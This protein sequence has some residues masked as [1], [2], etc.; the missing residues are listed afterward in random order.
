LSNNMENSFVKELL[1]MKERMEALYSQNFQDVQE[2]SQ[3]EDTLEVWRP[4]ADVWETDQFWKALI[5]LPGVISDELQVLVQGQRLV[6]KGVRNTE[7]VSEKPEASSMERPSGHFARSFVLPEEIAGDRI[8]AELKLG[9]LTVV[10][11]KNC[12]Q[13]RKVT[14][15]SE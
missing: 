15:R 5:D 3:P 7:M 14:V 2:V 10:I 12:K 6:V 8:K 1:G 11:P 13:S 4:M 9:V